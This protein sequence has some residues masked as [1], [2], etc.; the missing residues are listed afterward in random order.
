MFNTFNRMDYTLDQYRGKGGKVITSS[1]GY[2]YL[3]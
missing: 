1:D 3:S 2:K